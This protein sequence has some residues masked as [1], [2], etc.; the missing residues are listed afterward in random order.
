MPA[1]LTLQGPNM[2]LLGSAGPTL[3]GPLVV[4]LAGPID[5]V[6]EHPWI[7]IGGLFLGGWLAS[8]YAPAWGGVWGG[9]HAAQTRERALRGPK[10]RGSKKR[11]RR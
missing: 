7:F 3:L 2:S 8:K 6:K 10:G 9:H 5:A 1:I 4:P 11:R